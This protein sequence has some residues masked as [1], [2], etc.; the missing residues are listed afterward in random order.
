MAVITQNYDIDLK[1]TGEFPVVKMSQFDTGS[2]TI[3]FTVYDGH[4]LAGLDGMV[5]RV[6]G[7]RSDGVE[8]SSTCTVGTGSKVSFTISQEMTKHAGKHSAELVIFDASGNPAGTQ[9]FVIDVEAAPMVRDSAASADDRTLYD[10]FTDSVSKSVADKITQ[11]DDSVSKTVDSKMASVDSKMASVDSKIAG[12]DTQISAKV[13]N[14]LDS[15]I[16][17]DP[18]LGVWRNYGVNGTVNLTGNWTGQTVPLVTKSQS[19]GADTVYGANTTNAVYIHN[20]G[21]YQVMV[22]GW[23]ESSV[24]NV[25]RATS[26][27]L[28]ANS[29]ST[30]KR[31][32]IVNSTKG[33]SA[34]DKSLAFRSAITFCVPSTGLPYRVEMHTAGGS[35]ATLKDTGFQQMVITRISSTWT[36]VVSSGGASSGVNTVSVGAT[37]T[38]APGTQA[39]VVNSGTA[40]DVVLDF[41]IPR[42]ADGTGG[43]DYRLPAAS[44][45][46]LGGVKIGS[47]ISVTRDG[48]ISASGGSSYKLPAATSTIL[49]G[50]KIGSGITVASDGTISA[51]GGVSSGVNT[52]SI[53]TTT[54]GKP[55]TQASVV[56]SGTAKDV[57]L[58]FTIP[59]GD[60]GDKGDKGEKGDKGD[61]YTLPPATSTSLGGVK[62]GS[63]ITVSGDGTISVQAGG[64]GGGSYTLPPA[65]STTLGGVKVGSG[66]TVASDGT[67]SASGGGSY[68]LPAATSTTLGGIKVGNNLT[69]S[70]DGTLAATAY[71]LPAASATTLGGV[72]VGSG[73]TVSG[74]GTI[75]AQGG[76]DYTLPAASASTLGG[77]KIGS[78]ITVAGDGTISVQ[79]GGTGGAGGVSLPVGAMI[80]R[81]NSSEANV[82]AFAA[83]LGDDWVKAGTVVLNFDSPIF[84]AGGNIL[85]SPGGNAPRRIV[86]FIKVK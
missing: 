86:F 24:A 79:A 85:S 68:T 28:Y 43:G 20:P 44:A 72:K 36:P 4:D 25:G 80:F 32:W 73:I 9:N 63:G 31:I 49:G 27:E 10:Q 1:A 55:G 84:D 22:D 61:A 47:G 81:P 23:Y 70:D 35:G 42:G 66:I 48:T 19:D 77:V 57:V 11:I 38:G 6:D 50:V 40:K 62:V 37:V 15:R 26:L 75:S 69:V 18:L 59:K 2:R 46:T 12:V 76:G 51:Q 82:N 21:V 30:A 64:T 71:T 29:D 33:V 14:A 56:N 74:D 65:T 52:V 5:A 58:D 13:N 3:V 34:D 17:T 83:A 60:K 41:T 45:F 8:F 39:S 78:G 53:G 7:T 16:K 67:I 54:T